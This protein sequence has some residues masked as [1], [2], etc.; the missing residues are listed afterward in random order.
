MAKAA[1]DKAKR[2]SKP[3]PSPTDSATLYP[4]GTKRRGNDGRMYVVK[5]SEKTGIQ[6]WIVFNASGGETEKFRPARRIHIIDNGSVPF[7]VELSTAS[8]QRPGQARVLV[9]RTDVEFEE[10][11][12][13]TDPRTSAA[14]RARLYRPFKTFEYERAF[15][16][17]DPQ[18]KKSWTRSWWH[19]G[20]SV[21]LRLSSTKNKYVFIGE[22]IYEFATAAADEIVSF[23]SVMGNSAVPYPYAVS[24]RMTYLMIDRT[25][26]ENETL[27]RCSRATGDDKDP[28]ERFYQHDLATCAAFKHI[29]TA[30][31][32]MR[33]YT[34]SHSLPAMRE[35]HARM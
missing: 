24:S 12:G 30:N 1:N 23:V 15:V 8:D 35:L 9:R 33:A 26:I 17:F 18:E 25:Y 13:Q 27:Q 28:Y 10:A 16:G 34:A 11:S 29:P 31:K 6:R 22:S 21:L 2:S 4:P 20:N 14:L 19:G 5:R 32:R 3:R 7:V